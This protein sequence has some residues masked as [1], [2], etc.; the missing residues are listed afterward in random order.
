MTKTDRIYLIGPRGSGKTT[1]G[2]MLA[3]RLGCGFLD[4]DAELET[5]TG[6]T[7]AEIFTC[8]GESGFRDHE[9]ALLA[10]LATLDTH[11]VACGG[12]V[13]LRSENRKLLRATGL[14]IWLTGDPATLS[15]RLE[16]DPVS[17]SRR[18][19]LTD[20]PGP[21]EIERLVREREPL[22]REVAH[23]IVGTDG[24]PPDVIVSDILSAWPS[25]F[26]SP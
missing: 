18:P 3:Q 20:L 4:A 8:A 9:A 6:Q 21:A 2:R 11:V 23:L 14:C 1:V 12:G 7:V 10:A 25:S 17:A 15:R 19:A 5:R 22:Y 13:V 26:S 24:R 16:G